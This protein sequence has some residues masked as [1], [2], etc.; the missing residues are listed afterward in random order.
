MSKELLIT[1]GRSARKSDAF[2]NAYAIPSLPPPDAKLKG[3]E[4]GWSIDS[5]NEYSLNGGELVSTYGLLEKAKEVVE[6][7]ID[8]VGRLST[9]YV[10]ALKKVRSELQNDVDS[11]A[12]ATQRLG[13]ETSKMLSAY[14]SAVEIWTSDDMKEAIN[15][16]ERLTKALSE[17]AAVE[18]AKVSISVFGNDQN[19]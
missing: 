18:R 7:E 1:R 15:N 10:A 2:A 13:A 16:A 3:G 12:K 19:D 4:N 5:L 6:G 17:L 14:R 9:A 11:I 8:S